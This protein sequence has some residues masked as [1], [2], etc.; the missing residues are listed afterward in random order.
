M[1]NGTDKLELCYSKDEYTDEQGS[2]KK[3]PCDFKLQCSLDQESYID[4]EGSEKSLSNNKGVWRGEPSAPKSPA[5]EPTA[6]N[7]L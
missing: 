7:C 2:T 5:S 3:G 4:I 1:V 6:R